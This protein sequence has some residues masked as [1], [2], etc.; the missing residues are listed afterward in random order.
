MP[1][2]LCVIHANCQ[3]DELR[4]LL[5]ATPAFTRFFRIEKYTN[6]LYQAVPQASLQQCS[7]FCYQ[8]LGEHWNS[9]A[10]A[11]LLQ[12][13]P[14]K[15]QTLAI[16]NMFFNG[17]WPLW[18]NKT[19]M[20]FGDMFLEHLVEKGLNA[21]EILHI[22]LRGKLTAKYDLEVLRQA[23]FEKEKAKEEGLCVTTLELIENLWREEQLFFTINH[24]RPRLMLHVADG[25]LQALGLGCV[26]FSVRHSY[27][28]KKEEFELP[29]HPQVGTYFHLPFASVQRKYTIYGQ[30]MTVE[31][32]T[33]AYIHCR[34]CE[35]LVYENAFNAYL[36][37]LAQKSTVSVR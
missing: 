7:L 6:Y 32:Y 18:T 15:A 21:Q 12:K 3:G 27:M 28:Q 30:Q 9:Q 24:P 33:A 5:N 36:H 26:P 34:L 17:Y 2:E 13:L 35:D 1:Q 8:Y 23:S 25:L 11:K 22:Y 4:Y 16:P 19:H 14:P 20:N 10:T 31:Q 29:I 37:V